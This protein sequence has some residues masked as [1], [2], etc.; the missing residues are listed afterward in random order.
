M[1]ATP[2]WYWKKTRSP[3]AAS[4]RFLKKLG[5]GSMVWASPSGRVYRQG[6]DGAWYIRAKA[7][8]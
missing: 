8:G 4:W 5:D 7:Q 2:Q 3:S 1:T 6:P